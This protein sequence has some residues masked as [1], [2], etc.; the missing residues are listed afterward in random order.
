[1]KCLEDRYFIAKFREISC[2]GKSGRA[3][4][5]DSDLDAVC[6]LRLFRNDP[7]LSGPVGNKT[8][9]FTDG[10]SL[11]LDAADA[12]A[13]TLA[14]LRAHTAA[15]GGQQVVALDGLERAGPVLVADLGDEAGDVHAD[16]AALHAQGL[17][18]VEAAVGLGD[19]VFLGEARVDRAEIARALS[20]RLL[21]WSGAGSADVRAILLYF[22]HAQASS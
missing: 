20:G 22:W 12:L 15:D 10:N 17:L 8:L 11:A 14:L 1:M 6:L 19:G 3:G 13:F 7:V 2:T 5:D 9:K 18:A 21:V 4:T 16:G